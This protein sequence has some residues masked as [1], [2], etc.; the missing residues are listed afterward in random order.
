MLPEKELAAA[1]RKIN[2]VPMHGPFS[3]AVGLHRLF[4]KV[5]PAGRAK[6]QPLWGMGSKLHGARYTPK[7]SYETAYVARDPVTALAE[8]TAV[9]TATIGP[10]LALVTNPWVVIS[11]G[12][13]LA[14]VLDLT[15]PATVRALGSNYQ[16]LTGA[17]RY[18]SGHAGE[19]P[20]HLLGRVC[21]RSR[22]FDGICFP[23]S[24][25]PPHGVCVAIFPDRL[26]GAAYVE[27]YDP[28]NNIAQR[29]P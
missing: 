17:W 13:M 10:P 6:S 29:L 21:H 4:S 1:L 22:R 24:K 7:N 25:N 5:A 8:V 16:E 2:G 14:R 19:P 3:R 18:V 20:T 15:E 9:I 26:R 12:G 11:I 23:S 28:H 27:V